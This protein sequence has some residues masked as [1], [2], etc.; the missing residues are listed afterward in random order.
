M[1]IIV[2]RA[3]IS[4]FTKAYMQYQAR[5]Q[6]E[7][8]RDDGK[9]LQFLMTLYDIITTRADL[10]SWLTLP[11]EYQMTRFYRPANGEIRI[12][13]NDKVFNRNIQLPE[14][15]LILVLVK[16]PSRAAA[17]VQVIKMR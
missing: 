17:S 6:T 16:T 4:A 15:E 7:K 12:Q 8:Q 9:T 10:R 13:S 14:G 1:P 3:F 2:L 11:K 5:K